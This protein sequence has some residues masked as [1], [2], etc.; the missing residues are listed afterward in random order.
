MIRQGKAED[1][2]GIAITHVRAWQSTYKG[3]LPNAYLD[4]LSIEDRA[5]YWKG[6]LERGQGSNFVV[7]LMGR[8]SGFLM[9][10]CA[11][12][13]IRIH[14]N[15]HNFIQFTFVPNPSR[16]NTDNSSSK[17]QYLGLNLIT[18]QS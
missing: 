4:S 11:G 3:L 14:P 16:R 10:D 9:L 12:M 2:L 7:E 18:S 6:I 15:Q 1:A 13:E 5:E 17:N 8:S